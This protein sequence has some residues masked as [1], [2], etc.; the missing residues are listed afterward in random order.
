MNQFRSTYSV[1]S[2]GGCELELLLMLVAALGQQGVGS[3]FFRLQG[4]LALMNYLLLG[5]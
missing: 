5:G 4:T 3:S 2:A 1:N